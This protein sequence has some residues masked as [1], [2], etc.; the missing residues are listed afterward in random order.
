MTYSTLAL[1]ASKGA[2]EAVPHPKITVDLRDAKGRLESAGISV[3]DAR[4]M[5]IVAMEREVTLSRDGRIL[6]KSHDPKEA[7]RVFDRLRAV[8]GLP[9]RDPAGA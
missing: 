4:V 3:T 6:I 7:A 1:C 9:D 2:Y 8:V 5:L